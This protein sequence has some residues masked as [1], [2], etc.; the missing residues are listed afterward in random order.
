MRI[1]FSRKGFDG[2]AGGCASPLVDGRPVPLPIPDRSRPTPT[3]YG[4][5]GD[6]RAAMV[7][8][9]TRGRLGDAD[10]CH[11]DPD[12]EADVLGARPP[13]W[14]GALGQIAAAQGH[15]R[16]QRV[17]AGDLF[18]FFGLY[19]R[20]RREGDR[21]AWA[22]PARASRHMLFGWLQVDEVLG[23]QADGSAWLGRFPWLREHPHAREG[24]TACNT[25]YLARERLAFAA[26][27]GWGLFRRAYSLTAE[28]A[29]GPS[30][31]GVPEWLRPEAGARLSYRQNPRFW[32]E[33]GHLD[34]S[35]QFQEAVVDVGERAD[36]AE[37]LAG[38]FASCA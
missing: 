15:L 11:L 33:D 10:L 21:W 36:V 28:G 8:D 3:R 6:E 4:D 14:R 13:G 7:R 32:R 16:N 24:W 35:G 18:L 5:L 29:P 19:R 26:L 12:I 25:V 30:R 34:A 9:L 31:W 23:P 27:P 37:W 17:G 22:E 2:T 38:L 20:A 1:V